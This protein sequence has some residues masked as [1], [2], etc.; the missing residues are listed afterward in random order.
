MCE[1]YQSLHSSLFAGKNDSGDF[2]EMCC[3]LDSYFTLSLTTHL[4]FVS[5]YFLFVHDLVHVYRSLS[6]DVN[7][8][9]TD[10]NCVSLSATDVMQFKSL[11]Q[12]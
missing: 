6:C 1:L 11:H 7:L 9:H 2:S 8:C 5:L 12:I 4:I 3:L 10:L